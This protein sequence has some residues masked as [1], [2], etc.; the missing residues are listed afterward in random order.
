[1]PQTVAGAI[2]TAL[3]QQQ[4][5]DFQALAQRVSQGCTFRDAFQELCE[6]GWI[7][8]VRVRGPWLVEVRGNEEGVGP[9]VPVPAILHQGKE[10]KGGDTASLHRLKPL[11]SGKLPGW[12]ESL[13]ETE[14]GLR[15]LWLQHPAVTEATPGYLTDTGLRSF[16]EGQV[17][18]KEELRKP[19]QLF[20]FDHRTGIEIAADPLTAKEGGIYGASFLAL[21]PGYVEPEARAPASA[22]SSIALFT[23]VELP[24]S[25]P[26]AEESFGGI[27]TLA[28]GGEGRRAEV[29][30]FPRF[31]W[32]ERQP[33]IGKQKPLLLLTTPGLFEQRWKPKCLD[34][35]LTAAAVRGMA[36][37]SGWDLARG[38]PKP[39]R[40]AVAAGSVYFLESSPPNLPD[41]LCDRPED[42]A[43]GWGCYVKGVWR[44]E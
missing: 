15:P 10:S 16:L 3:L 38:G 32:P 20:G 7:A 11:P 28:L 23:E 34:G 26:P 43:Q 29:R 39:N 2:W 27:T 33:R 14:K 18:G 35:Y 8:D 9:L 24:A 36:A 13:K 41:S 22:S 37:V 44:D 5:C 17:P 25:A 6:A 19:D 4:G 31:D 21:R 1:M 12:N 40:F 42:K 30:L